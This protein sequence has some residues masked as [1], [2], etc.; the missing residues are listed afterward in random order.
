MS[1]AIGGRRLLQL[2]GGLV[3]I[4]LLGSATGF[5]IGRRWPLARLERLRNAVFGAPPTGWTEFARTDL[6]RYEVMHAVRGTSLYIFSGFYTEDP[7]VTARVEVLD[8]V[9]GA[10]VRK[11]DIPQPL[12]H[13][14]PVII[15]DTVWFVGGFEGDHPGPATTRVWRYDI[16]SDSWSNGP[17]LPAPRGGGALV[18]LGDTLHFF[19]GWLPDR[20]TDSPDHWTL[21]VGDSVWQPAAPLPTPRG[22]LSGAVL[23]GKIYALGGAIGHDP[24]P[25]DVAITHRLDLA[26]G[27]WEAAPPLPFAV[28]H[29]EPS[30]SVY[31]GR[32]LLVGGRGRSEGRGNLDDLLLFDAGLER[33]IHL[34]R[35]P[36]PILG[37]V[38]VTI[39]DT[40]FAG[41]GATDGTDPVHENGAI[42]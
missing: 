31:D 34:G 30:T 25:I 8:L 27:G 26:T 2:T 40:L 14:S 23:G 9:T 11:Q 29:A 37:G 28:S 36:K 3:L 13:T 17:P 18:A 35:T 21:V 19:G 4:L 12:T 38:T 15:R 5:A 39:G 33:W 42:D 10:W 20:N 7:K 1:S 24:V 16:A 32:I 41:L 22:H 6:P